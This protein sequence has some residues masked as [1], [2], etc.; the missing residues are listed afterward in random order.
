MR[1]GSK[2]LLTNDGESDRGPLDIITELISW[3][4]IDAHH[5]INADESELLE[6]EEYNDPAIEALQEAVDNIHHDIKIY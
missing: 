5:L 6:R 2:T 4:L 3:P 1:Q